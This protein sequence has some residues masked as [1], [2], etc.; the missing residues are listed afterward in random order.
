PMPFSK[1][2]ELIDNGEI[3]LLTR[4]RECMDKYNNH[5]HALKS[6]GVDMITNLI[7]N[8][9]HWAPADYRPFASEKDI[10][11]TRNSFPYYLESNTA[12]LCI[13]VKFPLLPDPSSPIGDISQRNKDLIERYIQKTFVE[14]LGIPRENIAWFKNWASLQSI[15]SIPHI[16][17]IVKG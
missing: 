7:V 12:H 11:I 15:K 4:S 2:R 1:A 5:R 16:H 6:K 17:V 3:Q 10:V 8:E 14:W 9:L 13:W